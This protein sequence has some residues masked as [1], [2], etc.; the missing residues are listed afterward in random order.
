MLK[1]RCSSILLAVLV[2]LN[3]P[4]T[5]RSQDG[6]WWNPF[7]KDTPSERTSSAFDQPKSFF[8]LPEINWFK[9]KP[10]T[11][12]PSLLA[13]AGRSTR[14]AWNS[15]ID[16]LNP[17]DDASP[18]AKNQGYQPQLDKPQPKKGMLDWM[19]ADNKEPDEPRSVNEWLKQDR[20]SY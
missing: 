6:S 16:F 2:S 13:R 18:P 10:K 12:Q 9:P 17:F 1:S 14:N 11:N 3:A 20:P 7:A 8:K 4:T 19:W 5:V 15:T